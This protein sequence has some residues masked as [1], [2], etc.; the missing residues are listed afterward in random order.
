MHPTAHQ[1]VPLPTVVNRPSTQEDLVPRV[2]TGP[3]EADCCVRLVGDTMQ[4]IEST[5]PQQGNHEPPTARP[6]TQI[7]GSQM[8]LTKDATPLQG[9]HEPPSTRP[10]YITQ[11]KSEEPRRGY[12]TRSRTT[13]IMQEAMLACINITKPQFK[14]LLANLA[15]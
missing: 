10:N 12:N 7:V 11:D 1:P 3:T 9:Y 6:P 5:T 13:S 15:V 2:P 4:I 14:I 8:Q